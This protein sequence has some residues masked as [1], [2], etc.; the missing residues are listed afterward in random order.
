MPTETLNKIVDL[1]RIVEYSRIEIIKRDTNIR[2]LI[3]E[4]IS[5]IN[6]EVYSKTVL[7]K[8]SD[9]EAIYVNNNFSD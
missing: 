5:I 6:N 4:V 1:D 8:I 7:H 3:N 2:L 9:L